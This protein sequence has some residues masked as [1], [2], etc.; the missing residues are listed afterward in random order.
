MKSI[1]HRRAEGNGPGDDDARYSRFSCHFQTTRVLAKKSGGFVEADYERA[2]SLVAE[3]LPR[4]AVVHIADAAF[5][6]W[7]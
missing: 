3:E 5:S 1:T 2:S 7:D 6:D 4:N